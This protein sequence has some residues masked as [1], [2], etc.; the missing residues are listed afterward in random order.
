MKQHQQTRNT[1]PAM[2]ATLKWSQRVYTFEANEV[3]TNI[4]S[5]NC[6]FFA[7]HYKNNS[8]NVHSFIIMN[9]PES[10]LVTGESHKIG[11]GEKA[12]INAYFGS[13]SIGRSGWAT[14]GEI[15]IVQMDQTTKA[16]VATFHFTIVDTMGQVDIVDGSLSLS[17]ADHAT[18]YIPGSGQVTANLDPAI[19][20]SLGNLDAQTITF[21]ELQDGRIQLSARQQVDNVSQGIL[22]LFN[23]QHARLLFL[24]GGLGFP[25]NGGRLQ[26]EWNVENKTLTATFT[27]YV[28]SYDG[29]DHRI[30]D[31]SIE[32]ILD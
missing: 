9:I 22:M 27:D 6:L 16:L 14:E 5:G 29:K 19:F 24:I 7:P 17:L 10:R 31:G 12:E 23:E 15:R 32:V 11:P 25:M 3:D 1:Q 4:S 21:K 8:E 18:R 26:H 28:I 2:Q 13:S 20:P 30:T